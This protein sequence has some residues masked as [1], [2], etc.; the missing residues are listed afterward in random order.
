MKDK[1]T[2]FNRNSSGRGD[3]YQSHCK[4]CKAEAGRIRR[5]TMRDPIQRELW[6]G[7]GDYRVGSARANTKLDESDIPLIRAL[8]AAKMPVKVVAEKFEV[9]QSLIKRID[10][11]EIWT[12]VA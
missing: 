5:A 9:S 1:A 2:C 12:H 3:G 8:R 11:R 6:S 4:A 7:R 10:R